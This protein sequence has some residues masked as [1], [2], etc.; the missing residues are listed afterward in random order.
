[1]PNEEYHLIGYIVLWPKKC[2]DISEVSTVPT[3]RKEEKPR[4]ELGG[5]KSFI[6]EMMER[7]YVSPKR[8]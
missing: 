4:R 3:F 5:I 1:M 2:T 7:H 8:R 6:S